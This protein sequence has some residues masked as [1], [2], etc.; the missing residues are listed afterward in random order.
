MVHDSCQNQIERLTDEVV[1]LKTK[2][3]E[4]NNK[5]MEL[6]ARMV[7]GFADMQKQIDA[8]RSKA[9]NF[10]IAGKNL[11]QIGE[12]SLVSILPEYTSKSCIQNLIQKERSWK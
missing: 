9:E 11:L 6:E 7:A 3:T 10:K 5:I 4:Q 8:E 12:Q 2:I 1:G